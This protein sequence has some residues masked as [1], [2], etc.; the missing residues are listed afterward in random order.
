MELMA[1]IQGLLA[2]KEPCE[3]DIT[4]DSEYVREGIKLNQTDPLPATRS[5]QRT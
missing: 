2:L 3:V 4:T 5:I 1:P